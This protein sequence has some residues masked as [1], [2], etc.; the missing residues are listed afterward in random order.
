MKI[1]LSKFAKDINVL[2][3]I[4]AAL[5]DGKISLTELQDM[6]LSKKLEYELMTLLA[7]NPDIVGD[8]FVRKKTKDGTT[9][10]TFM[11][12]Y[13]IKIDGRRRT[14]IWN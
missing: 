14:L 9:L 11:N 8:G 3:K 1:D 13:G 12:Q 7:G 2:K 10:T 4:Q 6:Q 5:L